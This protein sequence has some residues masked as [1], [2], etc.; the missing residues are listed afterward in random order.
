MA[1]FGDGATSKGDVYE[2][3][4]VAGAW[5]L[6]VVFVV[7]NNQWAISLPRVSQTAAET[8]AQKAIAAGFD[9]H[10][11]DGNDVIAVR[12][13]VAEALASAR[14]GGGP[15]LIEALTYRLADHT[16]A[17]DA[18]RYR[19]DEETARRW[20]EEPLSRLGS[21]LTVTHAWTEGEKQALVASCNAEVEQA[22]KSYTA[23]KP[24]SPEVMFD[25][26]Y[27]EVP[28][29]LARQRDALLSEG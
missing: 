16:T 25:Q 13:A 1:V 21:H 17:D 18:G 2:A 23:E 20:Q 12:H 22:V 10:Q 15:T 6:P 5:T 3:M 4:N 14:A 7:N 19:D 24:E 26:L 29:A 28:T 27:D 8:L 9:G 11:V